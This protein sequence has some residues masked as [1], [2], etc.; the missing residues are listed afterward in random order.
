M[1][2][3]KSNVDFE[4]FHPEASYVPIEDVVIKLLSGSYPSEKTSLIMK[5]I[6][7]SGHR[8]SMDCLVRLKTQIHEEKSITFA[9]LFAYY[10]YCFS[11]DD[12]L[13]LQNISDHMKR[14]VAHYMAL[15]GCQFTDLE[16]MRLGHPRD[17][18]GKRVSEYMN[19]YLSKQEKI[20]SDLEYRHIRLVFQDGS[21]F[22]E[23][24]E[25]GRVH[26]GAKLAVYFGS[27]EGHDVWVS[28]NKFVISI[29]Q[30]GSVIALEVNEWY[31]EKHTEEWGYF[32]QRIAISELVTALEA[33]IVRHENLEISSFIPRLENISFQDEVDVGILE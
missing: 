23:I 7:Q 25:W 28:E 8:F 3:T 27:W 11:I 13:M 17:E 14:A 16:L 26:H 20:H 15:G 30:N 29:K 12:L 22:F 2:E 5:L 33:S 6:I 4:K 9:H 31:G 21:F 19:W 10:G 32:E 24:S 1:P 18:N